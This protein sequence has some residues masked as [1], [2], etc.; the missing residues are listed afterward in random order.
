[1]ID[2]DLPM[3]ELARRA[4]YSRVHTSLVIYGHRKSQRAAQRILKALAA[5]S[6]RQAA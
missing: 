6:E 3:K 5:A 4:G 2:L 1:M